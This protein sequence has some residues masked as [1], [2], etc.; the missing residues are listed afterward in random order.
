V[1]TE[2]LAL[3]APIREAQS[4]V[5]QSRAELR[6]AAEALTETVRMRGNAGSMVVDDIASKH[7]LDVVV[8]QRA[9]WA[10]LADGTLAAAENGEIVTPENARAADA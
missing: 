9:L 8:V 2:S 4:E 5:R 10:L 7:G 3:P 6:R 1:L